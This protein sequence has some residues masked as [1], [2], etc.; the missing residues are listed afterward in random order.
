MLPGERWRREQKGSLADFLG[1]STPHELVRGAD[2]VADR[3]R[4]RASMPDQTR[5]VHA[6][7]RCASVLAVVETLLERPEGVLGEKKAHRGLEAS[8]DL[9]LEGLLDEVREAL[10][11]LEDDVAREPVRH[12][13]VYV[14]RVDIAALDVPDETQTGLFQEA[15]D[16]LHGV[17]ALSLLLAHGHR[18]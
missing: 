12:D 9:L 14:A 13:D 4:V 11:D 7:Q 3:L 1:N 5:P 16:L 15:E 8:R 2:G 17:R 6:E 18:A 10:G